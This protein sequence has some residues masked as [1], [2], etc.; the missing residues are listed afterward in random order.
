MAPFFY[1]RPDSLNMLSRKQPA[2]A[3]HI[4]SCVLNLAFSLR[5]IGVGII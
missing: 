1:I 5:D 3:G 2:T 4:V